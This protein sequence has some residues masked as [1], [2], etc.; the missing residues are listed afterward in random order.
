[1]IINNLKEVSM[2]NY[3]DISI[4][5]QGFF[6]IEIMKIHTKRKEIKTN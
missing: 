2:T 3:E 5:F 6:W 4:V 1:M